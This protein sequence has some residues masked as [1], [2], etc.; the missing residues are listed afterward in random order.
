MQVIAED[1]DK[2][3]MGVATI[4]LEDEQEKDDY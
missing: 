4:D 3:A 2:F 1:D